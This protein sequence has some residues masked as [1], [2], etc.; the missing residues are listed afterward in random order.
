MVHFET[1][2]TFFLLHIMKAYDAFRLL[3]SGTMLAQCCLLRLYFFPFLGKDL[4][5]VHVRETADVLNQVNPDIILLRT[6]A[7]PA[8]TELALEYDAGKFR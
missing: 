5:D 3:P 2:C 4:S 6:L 7:L 1:L 8:G